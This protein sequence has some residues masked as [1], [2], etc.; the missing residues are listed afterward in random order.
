MANIVAFYKTWRGQEWAEASIESIYN[1]VD[2]IVILCS[3]T[4]WSGEAGINTVKPVVAAWAAIHDTQQKIIFVD[5]NSGDQE[6]QYTYGMHYINTH[7]PTKYVMF[8]DTDEIWDMDMLIRTTKYLNSPNYTH[9][10][11]F[12]CNMY[13]YIKSPI[14]RLDPPEPC[15]PT[16]FYRYGAAPLVGPRGLAVSPRYVMPDV[17]MHHLTLVRDNINDIKQK[18]VLSNKGDG[19]DPV[20]VEQWMCDKWDKIGVDPNISNL[21]ITKGFE[22]YWRGVQTIDISE[23]PKSIQE[24]LNVQQ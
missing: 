11:A 13:T 23:L 4:N 8:V 12:C 19:V 2:K 6:A 20:D 21:H 16:I 14:Y 18:I 9:I 17:Y 24:R 3:N 5:Y 15:K 22:H 10:N 1:F 7:I